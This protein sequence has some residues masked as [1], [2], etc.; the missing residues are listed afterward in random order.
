MQASGN[1]H[2]VRQ[3]MGMIIQFGK[4]V[5]HLAAKSEPIKSLFYTGND[6]VW[7]S[8]QDNAFKNERNVGSVPNTSDMHNLALL[9]KVVI[10]LAGSS[11]DASI[12][13]S[14]K[15]HRL[16]TSCLDINGKETRTGD[17]RSSGLNLDL[18][19]LSGEPY[20]STLSSRD[21]R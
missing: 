5:P 17:E 4:F 19:S 9:T 13:R 11:A 10:F 8:A 16:C 3:F 2:E 6:F 1:V 18:R 12:S 21:R 14:K 7:S 20:R 15:T